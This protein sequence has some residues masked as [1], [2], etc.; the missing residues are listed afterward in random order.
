MNVRMP[1][2]ISEEFLHVQDEYLSSLI[3]EKGTVKITGHV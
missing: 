2:E 3:K 1:K